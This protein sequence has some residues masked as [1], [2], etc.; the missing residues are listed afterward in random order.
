MG[1]VQ[2]ASQVSILALRSVHAVDCARLHAS[3]FA[4]AWN[5]AEFEH[6]LLG[7]PNLGDAAC[8]GPPHHVMGFVL[9]RLAADEAEILTIWLDLLKKERLTEQ[10]T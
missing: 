6:L 2:S 5:E 4:H 7:P 9:S 10:Q 8:S 3:A 1:K